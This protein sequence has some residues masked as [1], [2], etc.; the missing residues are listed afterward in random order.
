MTM[1]FKFNAC[2][3]VTMN[4]VQHPPKRSI[5]TETTVYAMSVCADFV[6]STSNAL[7]YSLFTT[8]QKRL[9]WLDFFCLVSSFIELE[10]NKCFECISIEI[11]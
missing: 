8:K 5:P 1:R 2:V 10:S 9:V 11:K 4:R 6:A 7:F 3:T